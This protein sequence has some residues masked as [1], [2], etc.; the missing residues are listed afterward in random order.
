MQL[1]LWILLSIAI[2]VMWFDGI[3]PVIGKYVYYGVFDDNIAGKVEVLYWYG[4]FPLNMASLFLLLP[5][6]RYLKS[7]NKGGLRNKYVR[8]ILWFILLMD[9]FAIIVFISLHI[10]AVQ[11]LVE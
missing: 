2:P 4:F 6:Y 7:S 10:T 9:L 3:G 5:G 8:W 1:P 11:L